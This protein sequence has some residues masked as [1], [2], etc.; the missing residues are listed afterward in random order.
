MKNTLNTDGKE[1]GK[2]SFELMDCSLPLMADLPLR[3]W[4]LP[5]R[6]KLIHLCQPSKLVNRLWS[7]GNLKFVPKG[8]KDEVFGMAIPKELITE[9]IQQ[10]PYY[11]QYLEMVAHKTIDKEVGQKKTTTKADK[12]KKPTPAKQPALSK[13]TKLVEEKK[14]KPTPSKKTCKGKEKGIA[15]DEQVAQSLLELYKPKK[16]ST[17]DQY[18][19]QRRIPKTHDAPTRPS[20]L[21]QD[22]TSANV[23]RDTPSPADAKTGA[24]TEKSNK[25]PGKANVESEVESMVTIPIHQA[26]LSTPQQSTPIIDLTTPKPISPPAQEPVFT[27]TTATTLLPPPP[28]Q[29]QSTSVLELATRVSTLEKICANFKKKHKLQDKTT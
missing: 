19:F 13:Q 20:V 6:L 5:W 26:S 22:D 8:E 23:V 7:F 3:L 29:Q 9:A 17:T 28:P 27:A 21:P 2:N 4:R 12:P 24:D 15:T 14:S 11:Q 16:Q 18:I 10:L 25:E 1:T